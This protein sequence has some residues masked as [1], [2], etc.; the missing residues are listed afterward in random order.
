MTVCHYTR[1]TFTA[2][3][4]CTACPMLRSIDGTVY[5]PHGLQTAL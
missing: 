1:H 4:H 5:Y 2:T 3:G